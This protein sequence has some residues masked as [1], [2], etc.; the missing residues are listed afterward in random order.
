MGKCLFYGHLKA[1]GQYGDVEMKMI[2]GEY[3]Q[4][5]YSLLL[6]TLNNNSGHI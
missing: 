2:Y 5:F 3:T 6:N 1:N 4:Q